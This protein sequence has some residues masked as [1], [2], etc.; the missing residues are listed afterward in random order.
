MSI[1][2]RVKK[3]L[4]GGKSQTRV[5]KQLRISGSRV[6][7]L[8]KEIVK[9]RIAW[10][11]KKTMLHQYYPTIKSC[12]H[13]NWKATEIHN[14]LLSMKLNLSYS[15]VA[16]FVADVR[17]ND[18]L[19]KFVVVPGREAKIFIIPIGKFLNN[20]K[21]QKVWVFIMKLSYSK[22]QYCESTTDASFENFLD[23]N[24]RA[25]AFFKAV[26]YLIKVNKT[27]TFNLNEPAIRKRYCKFLEKFQTRLFSKS[28]R[29]CFINCQTEIRLFKEQFLFHILHRDYKRF[30]RDLKQWYISKVN[31]D[32]H[33]FT[34]IVIAKEFIR[35]E[36][37]E[38]R[39]L[40]I[41]MKRE[42]KTT[43]K[44]LNQK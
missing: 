16:R 35:N 43:T 28:K 14:H 13:K 1:K 21:N 10:N 7:K 36:K 25:L 15:T 39:S 33:P 40:S 41:K 11:K 38:M 19:S 30:T 23:C 5:A 18:R 42:L 4:L 12:V 17:K 29:N 27:N 24:K 9:D 8:A 20:G 44:F 37:S 32:I 6:S 31:L 26:P 3:L 2:K 22:Y 34:K